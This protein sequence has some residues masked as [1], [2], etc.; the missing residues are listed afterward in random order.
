MLLVATGCMLIFGI[1]LCSDY[2]DETFKISAIDQ[3]ACDQFLQG[4]TQD[5]VSVDSTVTRVITDTLVPYTLK[6]IDTSLTDSTISAKIQV[7]MDSLQIIHDRIK[8]VTASKGKK[9]ALNLTESPIYVSI[10]STG[11]ISYALLEISGSA[12]QAIL[13]LDDY[14]GV[15]LISSSGNVMVQVADHLSL[16]TYG[17]C[18][19]IKTRTEIEVQSGHYLLQFTKTDKTLATKFFLVMQK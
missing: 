19:R 8:P 3:V 17:F 16:E 18:R 15:N 1:L 9:V 11:T 5:S 14:V 4:E 6:S 7:I 12:G 13:Y 10:P 2:E